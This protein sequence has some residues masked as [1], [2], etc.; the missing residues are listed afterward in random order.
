MALHQSLRPLLWRMLHLMWRRRP[1][2]VLR[3]WRRPPLTSTSL[4]LASPWCPRLVLLPDPATSFDHGK[5]SQ[6]FRVGGVNSS[7]PNVSHEAD[8]SR[9]A[10][11]LV[12]LAQR[13]A[14]CESYFSRSHQI[15]AH[16]NY[17]TAMCSRFRNP[18]PLRFGNRPQLIENFL[19]RFLIRAQTLALSRWIALR[20]PIHPRCPCGSWTRWSTLDP[21]LGCQGRGTAMSG[22]MAHSRRKAR[23]CHSARW[24]WRVGRDRWKQWAWRRW[25]GSLH[26]SAP[27]RLSWT[28]F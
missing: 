10:L 6:D 1:I 21:Y 13:K 14:I 28:L 9:G 16:P 3:P 8:C 24:G 27:A 20:R 4:C 22:R 18:S 19:N 15:H 26:L 2:L 17:S 23:A 7:L 11:K 12:A 25:R 5:S